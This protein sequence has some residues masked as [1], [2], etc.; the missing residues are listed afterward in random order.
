MQG[1]PARCRHPA[2]QAGPAVVLP[3]G[4]VG[5]HE[6]VDCPREPGVGVGGQLV[7]ELQEDLRVP[8]A[9]EKGARPAQLGEQRGRSGCPE[10]AA[11]DGQDAAHPAQGD[12]GAVNGVRLVSGHRRLERLELAV[13]DTQ[14]AGDRGRGRVG[15]RRTWPARR[16]HGALNQ[17]R[18]GGGAQTGAPEQPCGPLHGLEGFSW[19]QPQP[20]LVPPR[21][22]ALRSRGD[23]VQG[24]LQP[25]AAGLREVAGEATSSLQPQDREEGLLPD[26][27]GDRRAEGRGDPAE[28]A[29]GK[30]VLQH[31]PV[32]PGRGQA[33]P[34]VGSARA[35]PECGA[36]AGEGAPWRVEVLGRQTNALW[37]A[38]RAERVEAGR[39]DPVGHHESALPPKRRMGLIASGHRPASLRA[40][41]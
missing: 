20:Q 17:W 23:L 39:R 2:E 31:T 18:T 36:G 7:D 29:R 8:R 14:R 12:P 35:A 30:V 11:E 21:R 25:S 27:V 13:F 6:L 40:G 9:T 4:E 24:H 34:V 28:R 37:G 19:G 38:G 15:R 26:D 1:V 41:A 5:R 3:V 33:P 22:A 16:S 10:R 32:A